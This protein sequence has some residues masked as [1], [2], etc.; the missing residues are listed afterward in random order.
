VHRGEQ[1]NNAGVR[2]DGD[3]G[4]PRAD[5]LQGLLG[6]DLGSDDADLGHFIG[7]DGCPPWRVAGLADTARRII[8]YVFTFGFERLPPTDFHVLAATFNLPFVGADIAV[9]IVQV[10]LQFVDLVL[11]T[12]DARRRF[13]TLRFYGLAHRR[14]VAVQLVDFLLRGGQILDRFV[15][16][17]LQAIEGL[18]HGILT[19]RPD[20]FRRIGFKARG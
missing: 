11:G 9:Q 13:C 6:G 2:I 16:A 5:R 15:Q 14:N 20:P 17:R 19:R 1:S 8:R 4:D 18:L 10:A 7:G 3:R 12:L